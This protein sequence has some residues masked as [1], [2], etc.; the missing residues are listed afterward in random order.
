MENVERER[1]PD[2]EE[3][4]RDNLGINYGKRKER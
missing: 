4:L 2:V 3:N 1:E